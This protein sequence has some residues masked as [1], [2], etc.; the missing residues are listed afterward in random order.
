M[1]RWPGIGP[2]AD[3]VLYLP[4]RP[5][6]ILA[7]GSQGPDMKNVALALAMTVAL[8]AN[9]AD[10]QT[11]KTLLQFSGSVGTAIG[12]NPAGDLTLSG[13]TLYGMT[14]GIDINFQGN[15]FSVGIDGTNYQ[16]LVTF[17]GN[18]GTANGRAGGAA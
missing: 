1:C 13:T 6:A 2:F 15:I 18:S 5:P 7:G 10:A 12:A 11:F 17:T 9:S 3:D 14:P 16:N 8:C 4:I